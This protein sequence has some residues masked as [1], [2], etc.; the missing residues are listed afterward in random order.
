MFTKKLKID[1]VSDVVCPWCVI[2]YRKLCMAMN[3]LKD[4]VAF[5]INWKAYQLH[6]DIPKQGLDKEEYKKIK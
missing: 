2:G 6:P 5:D 3:D 1:I 4:E